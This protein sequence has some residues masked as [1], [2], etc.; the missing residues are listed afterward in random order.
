[1]IRFDGIVIDPELLRKGDVTFFLAH[2]KRISEILPW[3]SKC[4]LSHAILP[5]TS[6]NVIL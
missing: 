5:R 3:D 1:M 4:Y 2:W 6:S